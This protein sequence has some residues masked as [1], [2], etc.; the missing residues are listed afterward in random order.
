MRYKKL[1][2]Q[3]S[4]LPGSSVCYAYQSLLLCKAKCLLPWISQSQ[5]LAADSIQFSEDY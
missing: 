2:S 3:Y 5:I 1:T 4:V